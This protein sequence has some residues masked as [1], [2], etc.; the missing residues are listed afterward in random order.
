MKS[1]YAGRKVSGFREVRFWR[2]VVG[3]VGLVDTVGS[4]GFDKVVHWTVGR[5]VDTARGGG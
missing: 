5:V 2:N 1:V 3:G 4:Q